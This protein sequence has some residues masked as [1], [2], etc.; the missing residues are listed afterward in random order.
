[1]EIKKRPNSFKTAFFKEDFMTDKIKSNLRKRIYFPL[2]SQLHDPI[3]G[4]TIQDLYLFLDSNE[5]ILI[6]YMGRDLQ[7]KIYSKE[8]FYIINKFDIK[9]T[10]DTL[11]NYY[12]L[13]QH[14]INQR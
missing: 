7:L 13:N 11:T 3:P 4:N 8:I 10:H 9:L 14:Q 2:K 1:M 5:R 12:N 6:E